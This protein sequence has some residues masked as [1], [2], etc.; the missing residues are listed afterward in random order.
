MSVCSKSLFCKALRAVRHVKSSTT[1]RIIKN[2]QGVGLYLV[3]SIGSRPGAGR[4]SRFSS[5]LVSSHT[6]ERVSSSNDVRT[7]YTDYT[8][9]RRLVCSGI[10]LLTAIRAHELNVANLCSAAESARMNFFFSRTSFSMYRFLTM[11]VFW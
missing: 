6:L 4:A 2:Q 5:R 8:A 9:R 1:Q 11:R 3:M 7:D 10:C